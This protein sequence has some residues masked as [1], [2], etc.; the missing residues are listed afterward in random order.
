MGAEQAKG[1]FGAQGRRT[2][3]QIAGGEEKLHPG[4]GD[5]PWQPHKQEGIC[6]ILQAVL[7]LDPIGHP[8]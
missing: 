8:N 3:G 6:C 2:D 5:Q 1:H 7:Y 4:Y